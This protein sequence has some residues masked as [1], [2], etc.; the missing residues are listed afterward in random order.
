MMRWPRSAVREERAAR[1]GAARVILPGQRMASR[2]LLRDQ[3]DRQ[4]HQIA[5]AVGGR[6][7]AVDQAAARFAGSQP[8]RSTSSE[9]LDLIR[10][11]LRGRGL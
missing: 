11:N 7:L 6:R 4:V 2:L 3:P 8:P 9:G 1:L 5:A 10:C